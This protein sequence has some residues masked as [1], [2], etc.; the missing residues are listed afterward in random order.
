MK[1]SRAPFVYRRVIASLFGAVLALTSACQPRAPVDNPASATS[2]PSENKT[3]ATQ[4]ADEA[5]EYGTLPLEQREA[6]PPPSA[7]PEWSFPKIQDTTLPNGL[8]IKALQRRTLPLV[9]LTLVVRSGQATD[10]PKPGLAV[11][12]GE[13]LK[14]GGT[15]TWASHQLLDRV[16]SLG[17]SLNVVTSRDFTTVSMAVTSDR[18]G[19]AIE[20]L[21][22]IVQKPTFSEV[23]FLKLKRREMDR[24]SSQ[25]RTS[26]SWAANMVL[27]RELYRTTG[28]SHPYATYDATTDQVEG[29][30]LWE[31]K[32]WHSAHFTP[33]NAVLVITGDV[34]QEQITEASTQAFGAWRGAKV[35]RPTYPT[36]AL[37]EGL[38]LFL[39]H[40]PKSSQA[41][42]QLAL[43]GPDQHSEQY[44]TLKVA[45]QVL[46]GGV[47][48]RLFADVREKR[49]LAYST[50]SSLERMAQGPQPL[51]L[52]AGT[53][54]ARAG[55][56]LEALLQHADGLVTSAPSAEETAVASRYLS[57]LFLL[58][59][60][61][62]GSLGSM[63]AQL[64]VFGLDNGYYDKYRQAVANVSQEQ[65]ASV[66][67]QYFGSTRRIAVIAG[68]ADRLGVP[69]SRFGDVTVID[70]DKG[71]KKLREIPHDPSATLEL[72]RVDGT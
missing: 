13:M 72:E 17:S 62:V 19:D 38:K 22:L 42:L 66:A 45:N 27:F 6:P 56:T 40:R 61:T 5:I 54:T 21:G 16:E 63:V 52:R 55:L 24:V 14:V 32:R 11:L 69:L 10:G 50:N 70:P 57:D 25:A 41:E 26:A 15:G 9:E 39:V 43:F 58:R 44:P 67:K 3:G 8:T 36:P 51:V 33:H 59:M 35:Q 53:Q 68:D 7:A 2:V 4:P 49:S 30:Q 23:E 46:G 20:L 28:A 64:A 71:F 31:V 37:G 34:S 48:G 29:V 18:F 1:R 12:T 60:E 47:A 65:L